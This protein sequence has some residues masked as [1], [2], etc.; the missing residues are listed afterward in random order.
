MLRLLRL[1]STLFIR[2]FYSRR[3]L[4]LE[5]LALRQQRQQPRFSAPDRLFWVILRRLWSGWEQVLILVQPE[6]VVRWHRAGFKAYW[7]WLSRHRTCPGRKR[8]SAELRELIFRMVAEI[9][10][11]VRHASTVSWRC[12]ASMFPN[13]PSCA[14]CA[15]RRGTLSRRNDG[16][17][18]S[19]I[20][21]KLSPRWISSPCR[22]SH[23]AFSTASLSSPMTSGEFCTA[24]FLEPIS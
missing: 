18:F 22:R 17:R 19:A 4:L 6:T 9:Q 3:D 14:G 7:A 10:P 21:G 5:N 12:L 2:F 8:I 16:W 24:M 15:E 20:I 11:G 23:S 1:L 13:E